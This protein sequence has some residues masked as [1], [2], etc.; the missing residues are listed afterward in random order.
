MG[1]WVAALGIAP[2]A[3]NDIWL[4]LRTGALILQEGRVPATD[5]YSYTA[6][7]SGYLAHGWLA[8]VLFELIHR[9]AGVPGLIMSR[10]VVMGMTALFLCMAARAAGARMAAA[11]PVVGMGLFVAA[12]RLSTRP[13]IFSWLFTSV[14]LWAFL[15]YR[16]S[17]RGALWILGLVPVQ[18]LWAN[19]HGGGILGLALMGLFVL[20][21]AL[22]A[23]QEKARLGPR[24]RIP[25]V[26]A[27]AGLAASL[28]NP[29]GYRLLLL[30]F[31]LTSMSLY[32]ENIVEW[33]PPHHESFR[34]TTMMA[35][36]LVLACGL[37][38]ALILSR[39]PRPETGSG[40]VRALGAAPL[41][42]LAVSLPLV[43]AGPSAWPPE[44]AAAI[45]WGLPLLVMLHGAL[46]FRTADLPAHF[47]AAAFMVLAARHSR[48]VADAALVV[49]VLGA[50]ALSRLRSAGRRPSGE[51]GFL[52]LGAAAVVLLAASA[53]VAFAGYPRNF[54]GEVQ[55][56]GTGLDRAAPVCAV[57]LI[58]RMGLE[59]NAFASYSDAAMLV[60]RMYPR[61][62][63]NIDSRNDVYGEEC[64]REYRRALQSVEGMRAFLRDHDVS[65]FL[66]DY[67]DPAPD[68][69]RYLLDTGQW[70]PVHFDSRTFVLVRRDNVPSGL[71]SRHEYRVL[72]PS[73]L[74]AARISVGNAGGALRE[75][76]RS[77][78]RC[79]GSSFGYFYKA[80][81]LMAL[82]RFD[83]ALETSRSAVEADPRNATAW[84]D[85][86][87]AQAALGR[88]EAAVASYRKALEIDPGF[89]VARENLQKL[90]GG[91]P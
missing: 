89:A 54:A 75:A 64:Y 74:G 26:A 51:T 23:L 59:G 50:A 58:E 43:A 77:L 21:E 20:S 45:S 53:G 72:R 49:S 90:G 81:A 37:L 24:V 79:P 83:E 8:A 87:L 36:W 14:Y 35:A 22:V 13:H 55:P 1:A 18:I 66:L 44:A 12:C 91:L 16:R 80:K 3:S 5:V 40:M 34:G 70:A 73:A 7:G 11:L 41:L 33:Q 84:A 10:T 29:Y 76:Q 71:L 19:I 25:L 52:P 46:R 68:V 60:H 69:G 32:M 39:T 63:V 86:G 42:V 67:R 4:H 31:Q 27:A 15:R 62:K 48:S 57:D 2:L 56:R 9:A 47:L 38:A 78:D 30:P 88:S 65:F 17:G 82:G 61:V 85:L 28:I 6:A